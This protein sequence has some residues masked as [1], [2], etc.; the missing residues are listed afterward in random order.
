MWRVL[1]I[2]QCH[3]S[4]TG[5]SEVIFFLLE[6][7]QKVE[8]RGKKTEFFTS[9]VIRLWK[10]P[11]SRH[12]STRIKMR[13]AMLDFSDD[14]LLFTCRI[15]CTCSWNSQKLP[16]EQGLVVQTVH[17]STNRNCQGTLLQLN[18]TGRRSGPALLSS[19]SLGKTDS[20]NSRSV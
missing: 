17:H 6:S 10:Q 15:Y 14:G 4:V 20:E 13:P 18:W 8:K 16:A 19:A 7:K 12:E 1:F 3:A 9:I 2:R 11:G 5:G